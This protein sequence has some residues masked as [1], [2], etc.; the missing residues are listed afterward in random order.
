MNRHLLYFLFL[1]LPAVLRAQGVPVP[2]K[3]NP[4]RLVNDLANVMTPD[5]VAALEHK[6]VNYD[7]STSNQIVIV[8]M[9]SIGD[10]DIEEY[11]VKLF[12]A[13]GIGNKKTTTASSSWSRSTQERSIS[14][15]AMASRA[16]SPM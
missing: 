6:L 3:P 12:K 4:N 11:S 7:D 16:P 10:E 13:W 1:I 15:P 14:L 8:T 5:Q 2:A 9:P